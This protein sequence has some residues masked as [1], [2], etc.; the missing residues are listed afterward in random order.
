MSEDPF[1]VLGVSRQASLEQIRAA[2]HRLA[3]ETHPDRNPSP[4]ATRRFIAVHSAWIALRDGVASHQ[5]ARREARENPTVRSNP[6]ASPVPPTRTSAPPKPKRNV[7]LLFAHERAALESGATP[8]GC[9][10]VRPEL[11]SILASL[12][13]PAIPAAVALAMSTAHEPLAA[14]A[15]LGAFAF[16][17][18]AALLL[19]VRLP[20]LLAA[21]FGRLAIWV[22][23]GGLHEVRGRRVRSLAHAEIRALEFGYDPIGRLGFHPFYL[24]L[25]LGPEARPMRL[26]RPYGARELRRVIDLLLAHDSAL[27]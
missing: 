9:D 18:L 16:L 27:P 7:R 10:V 17:T 8:P 14:S 26:R 12:A 6:R 3:R 13:T 5:R 21:A 24:E 2:Y 19:A 11:R 23:P 25:L 22:G 4:D 1:Q 20:A 15:R